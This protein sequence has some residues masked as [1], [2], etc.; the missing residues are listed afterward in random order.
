MNDLIQNISSALQECTSFEGDFIHKLTNSDVLWKK[1]YPIAIVHSKT[2]MKEPAHAQFFHDSGLLDAEGFTPCVYTE[3]D[4]ALVRQKA[5]ECLKS[6]QLL[7]L[8]KE[9]ETVIHYKE[10]RPNDFWKKIQ[11]VEHIRSSFDFTVFDPQDDVCKVEFEFRE[12]TRKCK[13]VHAFKNIGFIWM[14]VTKKDVSKVF[15]HYFQD[16]YALVDGQYH[17]G[18][19]KTLKDINMR[20]FV[21]QPQE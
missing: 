3:N 7:A 21:C 17:I 13:E 18:W 19:S 10:K 6:V 8:K 2:R 11:D 5:P 14:A 16:N 1:D 9:P 15:S 20:Y 4:F 12:I